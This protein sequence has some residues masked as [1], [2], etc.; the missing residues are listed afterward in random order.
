[1]HDGKVK[2]ERGRAFM[3]SQASAILLVSAALLIG[4]IAGV[5]WTNRQGHGQHAF[6]D[7]AFSVAMVIDRPEAESKRQ[8]DKDAEPAAR[9]HGKQAT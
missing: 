9:S 2:F 3:F 5:L 1:M 6:Y 8:D 4:A 7:P